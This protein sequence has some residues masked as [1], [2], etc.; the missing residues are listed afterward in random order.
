MDTTFSPWIALMVIARQPDI[1]V[2]DACTVVLSP[3]LASPPVHS[4]MDSP[5]GCPQRQEQPYPGPCLGEAATRSRSS[6]RSRVSAP[7]TGSRSPRGRG[8]SVPPPVSVSVSVDGLGAVLE[9]D[10]D[11]EALAGASVHVVGQICFGGQESDS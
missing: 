11:T 7:L 1:F 10:T 6:P 2:V 5:F 8:W 4:H 9:T 3:N